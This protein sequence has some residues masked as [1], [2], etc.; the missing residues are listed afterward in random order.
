MNVYTSGLWSP[1]VG[2]Y[3]TGPLRS[4]EREAERAFFNICGGSDTK[5]TQHHRINGP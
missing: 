5:I 3:A 1:F 2:G 4:F